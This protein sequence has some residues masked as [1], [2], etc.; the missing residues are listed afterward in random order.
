MCLQCILFKLKHYYLL[1]LFPLQQRHI[2]P[3][4]ICSCNNVTAVDVKD[5]DHIGCGF[6][7]I[8]HKADCECSD[9]RERELEG[10]KERYLSLVAMQLQNVYVIMMMF[11]IKMDKTKLVI[12]IS[13]LR[14]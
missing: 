11:K 4:S 2:F 1:Q 7:L 14:E 5:H 12:C 3:R 13:V 10:C 6:L 8:K 9:N